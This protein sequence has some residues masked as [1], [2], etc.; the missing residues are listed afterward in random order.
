MCRT[1]HDP[2]KLVQ[3]SVL[4]TSESKIPTQKKT[5]KRKRQL[6]WK[7]AAMFAAWKLNLFDKSALFC[8]SLNL[9]G[10]R[11]CINRSSRSTLSCG[12]LFLAKSSTAE[13]CWAWWPFGYA[14]WMCSRILYSSV[15][16]FQPWIQHSWLGEAIPISSS[17]TS[18]G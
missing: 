8:I 13:K 16:K 3:A 10:R 4:P 6:T 12:G 9:C 7:V 5:G 15:V 17:S 18:L 14:S 11:L 2:N 1:K